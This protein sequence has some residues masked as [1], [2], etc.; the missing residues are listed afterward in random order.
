MNL[1]RNYQMMMDNRL[2]VPKETQLEV[3]EG[4]RVFRNSHADK[5]EEHQKSFYRTSGNWETENQHEGSTR[6]LSPVRDGGRSF[7]MNLHSY[8]NIKKTTNTIDKTNL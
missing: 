8:T 7:A 3:R 6:S 2:S 4:K 1:V 5:Q